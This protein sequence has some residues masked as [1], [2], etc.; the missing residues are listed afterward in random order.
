MLKHKTTILVIIFRH[1][2]IVYLRSESSQ[3]KR[4]LIS[5]ITN[6]AH[7]LPHELPSD[8]RLRIL[9]FQEILEKC[10]MQVQTQPNAQ[11]SFQKLNVDNSCQKIRKIRYY[12]FEVLPNSIVSLYFVPNIL[13]RIVGLGVSAVANLI[14][15][16]HA[17][18]ISNC[19]I[20][21]DIYLTRS[22]LLR[23]LSAMGVAAT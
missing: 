6:L 7:E 12:I 19:H 16:L 10:Q 8:L 4:Y 5:S 1:F 15:K 23:S 13:S 22:V 2:L 18:L 9:R 11:S 17:M 3:V 21:M 14:S 20:V